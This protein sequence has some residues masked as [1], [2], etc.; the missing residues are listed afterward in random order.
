M[1]L[2][3]G[4]HYGFVKTMRDFLMER[5]FL[6]VFTNYLEYLDDDD[7]REKSTLL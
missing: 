5:E 7:E 2:P 3:T 4:R 6:E 1:L